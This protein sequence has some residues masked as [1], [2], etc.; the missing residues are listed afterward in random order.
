MKRFTDTDM[1]RKRWF[2]QLP[3]EYKIAW[4]YIKDNS[5]SVG[6]WDDNLP[7]ADFQIGT[8]IDWVNFRKT[9][10]SNIKVLSEDKWWLVDF[11]SFQYGELSE[12]SNSKPVISYI[13][14]LKK[15]R[16][17]KGY[18]KGMYTLKEKEKD[19][20]QEQEK[21]KEADLIIDYYNKVTSQQRRYSKASRLP[22]R[23][24]L[25]D[26]FSIDECK[27]VI[28]SKYS[29][30]RNDEDMAKYITIETFFRPSHFEKYLNQEVGIDNTVSDYTDMLLED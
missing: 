6:V 20:E 25:N 27:K 12:E 18:I 2:Q 11:C 10:N 21:D 28:E 26:Q 15:H 8:P 14:Q 7:L 4:F 9:T 22:I 29:Q 16:L 24:R 5:D 3:P 1:W 17:W 30:W 19:K 13:K 23:A